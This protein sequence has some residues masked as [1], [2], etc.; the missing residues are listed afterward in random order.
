MKLVW[1]TD[2]HLDLLEQEE[3]L[4]FYKQI[5]DV[6][7]DIILITGDIAEAYSV[8]LALKEMAAVINKPL[9]FVLGNHDY[10]RGSVDLVR[11][12]MRAL[13]QQ[14][15][16]LHWL[17]AAG[18][19]LLGND[20]VLLGQDGWADGRCGDYANSP[21]RLNDCRLI[22]E[23]EQSATLGRYPLLEAMQ[24]LADQDAHNL[25]ISLINAIKDHRPKKIIIMMHV[26]PFKEACL[27]QGVISNDDYL[28]FFASKITGDLLTQIAQEHAS[29]QFIVLCGHTHSQ[30]Y[31]QPL[32][33]LIIKVGAAD[34]M[35]PEIQ[36]VIV[37]E[38]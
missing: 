5:A 1:L 38:R 31:W 35:K 26:P 28:P 24:K 17:P 37:I 9:Y 11:K 2:I 3:R 8:S 7:G 25:K 6:S 16:L 14:E 18:V 22:L 33:N 36:E 27:Y 34:Y 29:I 23:L 21:V 20:T 30:A 19:Q 4:Y 13:T 12:E 15:P 10:Y 32:D